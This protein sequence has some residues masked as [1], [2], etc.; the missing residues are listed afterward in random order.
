[1]PEHPYTKLLEELD[2][3]H[4]VRF[5][6]ESGLILAWN[7]AKR[8]EIYNKE[9]ACVDFFGLAENTTVH[10]AEEAIGAYVSTEL[11]ESGE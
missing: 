10:D 6:R 9:G 3:A 1:M 8:V 4:F 5:D 2:G 11:R 7:G